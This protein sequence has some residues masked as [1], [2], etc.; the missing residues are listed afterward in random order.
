MKDCKNSAPKY[1]K[2]EIFLRKECK[3]YKNYSNYSVNT[4]MNSAVSRGKQRQETTKK[5]N[6]RISNNRKIKWAVKYNIKM[7]NTI[8]N[9]SM[10]SAMNRSMNRAM[11][12]R[13]KN[14]RERN[15][16]DINGHT[17]HVFKI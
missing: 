7:K 5:R 1:C 6:R 17:I 8:T 15:N 16:N 3:K 9:C 13:Y 4:K 14:S 11:A 2:S 10:K 12:A